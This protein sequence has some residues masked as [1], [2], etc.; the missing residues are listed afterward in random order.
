MSA[1]CS[2][3]PRFSQIRELR[4]LV[5]AL[6]D[7]ARKLRGGDHRDIQLPRDLFQMREMKLISCT[8][9]SL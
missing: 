8:R 2:M 7:R 9:F 4:A 3:L 5:L 6:L 1:S